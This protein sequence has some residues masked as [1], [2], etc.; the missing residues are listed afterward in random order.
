[1]Q[2]NPH[3][4]GDESH[5]AEALRQGFEAIIDFVFENGRVK[6]EGDASARFFGLRLAD[7]LDLLLR[8]AALEALEIHLAVSAHFHLAPFGQGVYSR[9]THAVQAAR[10]LVAAAA[11]LAASMQLGHHDFQSGF[12][13]LRVNIDRDTAPVIIHGYAAVGMDRDKDAVAS[14]C[15]GFIDCV[16]DHLVDQVVQ[17]FKVRAAHVHTRATPHSFQAF[18]HLNVFSGV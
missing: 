7:H 17:G 5:F 14:A 6:A 4:P 2:A 18:Q 8:D 12:V 13:Q 9:D 16:I 1:M 10:D 11:E 3:P 15:Q